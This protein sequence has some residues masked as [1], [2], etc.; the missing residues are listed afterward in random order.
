VLHR[1]AVSDVRRLPTLEPNHPKNGFPNTAQQLFILLASQYRSSKLCLAIHTHR[2]CE[3]EMAH[4]LNA[5]VGR[6][7]AAVHPGFRIQCDPAATW[8]GIPST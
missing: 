5:A 2:D 7:L 6:S 4:H 8:R 1:E 3:R